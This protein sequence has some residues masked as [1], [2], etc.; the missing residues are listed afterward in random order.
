MTMLAIGMVLRIK[1]ELDRDRGRDLPAR[2]RIRAGLG[3]P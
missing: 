2:K 1:W 3:V